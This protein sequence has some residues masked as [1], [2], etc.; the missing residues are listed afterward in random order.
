[1]NKLFK[2]YQKL[3][4]FQGAALT[5]SLTSIIGIAATVNGINTFVPGTTISSAEMNANFSILKAAIEAGS[6]QIYIGTYDASL[7]IDPPGSA[8]G[9][10][11]IINKMGIINSIYYDIGDWIIFNGADWEKISKAS[12]ITAST[13]LVS[14]SIQT[15]LQNAVTIN[16]FNASSGNTG[17]LRFYELAP[18]GLEY[19]GFKSPDS[20]QANIL[21]V[22]PSV[23]PLA[24]Q[25]LSSDANKILSWIHTPSAAVLDT[26]TDGVINMA[27]SQNAVFDALAL[28]V[29]TSNLTQIITAASLSASS[30]YAFSVNAQ[31]ITGLQAPLS[32]SDAA[33]KAYI[34]N[35]GHWTRSGSN[36]TI[37][38]GNVGIGTTTPMYDLHVN[39]TVASTT[40]FM[41]LSDARYK[42]EIKTVPNALEKILSINGVSYKFRN[43]EFKGL[44]F[45]NHRELGVIAQT[46]EKVFPEAVSKD[47]NGFRSVAYTMLI[48]PIIEALREINSKTMRLEK[49]NK[50]LKSYLCERD[51]EA[52]FCEI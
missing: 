4:F 18:N 25:V 46:V 45:S 39:G 51:P 17:L 49:E 27:P 21:Y 35:L 24:G 44:K 13:A 29:D 2:A 41:N 1:M 37:M 9:E 26:I 28:K 11:Y 47:T 6:S 22:L 36:L 8:P 23:A 14:G 34:D 7:S 3:T 32:P 20:L 43:D 30:I 19:T 50:M 40:S 52:P 12:A 33:N 31:M 15:N 48:S 38:T 42:K 16:P 10:Y 5:I